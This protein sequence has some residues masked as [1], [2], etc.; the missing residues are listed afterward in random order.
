MKRIWIDV[1]DGMDYKQSLKL[2]DSINL[3]KEFIVGMGIT[4]K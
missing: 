1:D 3:D 2:L 4:E